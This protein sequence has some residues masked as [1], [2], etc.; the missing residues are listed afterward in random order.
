MQK[1]GRSVVVREE[2]G[3]KN[4]NSARG[5]FRASHLLVRSQLLYPAGDTNR[6]RQ[7]FR[8][9]SF[10]TIRLQLTYAAPYDAPEPWPASSSPRPPLRRS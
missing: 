1:R 10:H 8:A 6:K 3:E 4:R 2:E 5:A 7:P 9:A